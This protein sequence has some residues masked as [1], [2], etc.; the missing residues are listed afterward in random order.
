MRH[1]VL[2]V[3]GCPQVLNTRAVEVMKRMSD[4]LMGRDYAP[5]IFV[6]G[7]GTG[8]EP[9]SV[10]AQVRARGR[11]GGVWVGKWVASSAAGF[12]WCSRRGGGWHAAGQLRAR[13]AW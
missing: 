12:L 1:V 5:D 11:W 8:L 2:G 4:K 7:S 10:A 6:G 13:R 9:D 3:H